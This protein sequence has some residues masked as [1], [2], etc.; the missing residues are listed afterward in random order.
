MKDRQKQ[1]RNIVGDLN[2]VNEYM[3][4]VHPEKKNARMKW[5][6]IGYVAKNGL[7]GGF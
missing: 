5:I 3:D 1:S 2:W 6:R 7:V 4:L